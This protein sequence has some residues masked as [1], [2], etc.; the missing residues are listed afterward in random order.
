MEVKNLL[1]DNLTQTKV[2]VTIFSKE[3]KDKS[4]EVYK[5]LR[6]ENIIAEL[7]LDE[8]TPLDKQLKYA[9]KKGIPYVLIIGPKEA[10]ENKLTL[11]NM[12]TEEQELLSLEESVK[13]IKKN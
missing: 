9:D 4:L 10:R 1:P 7:Y 13:K 12:K 6:D 5:K 3:L 2:L 8:N 11:K